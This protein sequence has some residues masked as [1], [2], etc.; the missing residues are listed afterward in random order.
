MGDDRPLVL[1]GHVWS[2]DTRL[3]QFDRLHPTTHGL[4]ALAELAAQSLPPDI[5]VES[6]RSDPN[7]V[8][9]IIAGHAP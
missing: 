7:D 5:V 3:L 6:I 9:R 2:D 8:L 1:N 4:V